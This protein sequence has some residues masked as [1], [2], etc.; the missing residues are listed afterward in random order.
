MLIHTVAFFL[1]L[2]AEV[3]ELIAYTA[4]SI[5]NDDNDETNIPDYFSW[6]LFFEA[7]GSFIS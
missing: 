1:Y 4:Y 5:D 2:F 6:A 7:A 3:I